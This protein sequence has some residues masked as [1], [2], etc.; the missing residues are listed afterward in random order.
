MKSL[1]TI[2]LFLLSTYFVQA[3]NTINVS[4][5]GFKNDEGKAMVGL[6]NT[7]DEFLKK[8]Y[9]SFS[10]RIINRKVEVSFK[11]IPEGTFAISV[12]HDENENGEFD[13][14]FGMIPKENYGNSNNVPPR[15]GPPKWEDA[16]FEIKRGS[17]TQIEIEMM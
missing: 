17:A 6:Y 15:F 3:Q 8:E 1:L 13:R 16:K 5:T 10:A 14:R 11:D 2:S 12:Y 9:K 4:I 7:K